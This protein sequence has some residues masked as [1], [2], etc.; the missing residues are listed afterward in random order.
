M[1]I[2]IPESEKRSDLCERTEENSGSVVICAVREWWN[3]NGGG[4]QG[5]R[6][7]DSKLGKWMWEQ[8]REQKSTTPNE[9]PYGS[10]VCFLNKIWGREM[11]LWLLLL[12]GISRC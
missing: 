11:E 5:F 7:C 2:K 4:K 8:W 12:S 3:W 6:V 9:I 1:K 10:S